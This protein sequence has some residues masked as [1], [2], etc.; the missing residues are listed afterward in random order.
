MRT[1][2]VDDRRSWRG[3]ELLAGA[4]ALAR[5]IER[6]SSA[7]TVGLLIP[8]SGA[9]AMAA[10]AGWMA[11]RT[12]VPMNYLLKPEELQYIADDCETDLILASKALVEHMG[13]H[14]AGP[15]T[16][17]LEDLTLTKFR[18]VP[19]GL[20]RPADDA[21]LA[22]LLYTSGTSGRPKGVMLTHG[23]L[24]ANIRQA[25]ES[26][27]LTRADVFLGVLPQFHSF[28]FT[29]LTLL[30]LT[31]GA[32]VVYTARFV[33]RRLIELIRAQRASVMIAIPSMY[34]AMLG[35]K[36]AKRDDFDSL[37]FAVSG[38]E[39]LPDSIAHGMRDRFGVLVNEGYGLTETSPLTNVCVP[40]D[41]A[42]RS[43]G[44]PVVMLEQRI[45][46]PA[47]ERVLDAGEEGEVRMRGPNVMRGYFKLPKESAEA[48][49]AH[50]FFRSGDIGRMDDRGRLSITGRL[51][52]M[53]IVGGENVFPREIE[54][55]LNLHP[56]VK[57]S[58]VVGLRDDI[59]GEVP[60]A[61]VELE[62][63]ANATDTELR[64]WCR[65]RIAGYK[66]PREV[67]IVSEL[68]RNPTGKIVRRELAK[69]VQASA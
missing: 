43:V 67:R 30:P 69:M 9:F 51:K 56:A 65:D 68:P 14:P 3:F 21:D 23:N 61:F 53:L 40:E 55:V 49:D 64:E 60:V 2:I 50:G 7:P 57:G 52:E 35:V 45:V 66:I 29:V 22:C 39:P 12:I 41:F 19:A 8:T 59:R 26:A 1:A 36:S 58:G 62:D 37:R 5:E 42:P 4:A 17:F 33:P 15:R 46:D 20:L 34:G 47:T 13:H 44:R 11:G 32:K 38:G 10:L 16:T 54:E 31:I 27:R 6:T 25:C 24:R 28:G 63:G 18:G 48:F